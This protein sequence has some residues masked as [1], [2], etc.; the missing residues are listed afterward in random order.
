[1]RISYLETYLEVVRSGSFSEAAK[2][3]GVSQSAISQQVTSLEKALSCTL[4]VRGV[5]GVLS[6]TPAGEIFLEY[7]ETIVN[8]Y[9]DMLSRI[10]NA[11]STVKG[12]LIL[13]ASAIP[14]NYLLPEILL[15]FQEEY[16]DV[17]IRLNVANT[18]DVAKKLTSQE[19]EIGFMGTMVELPG[20]HMDTWVE[21]KIAFAVYP[22]HPFTKR[23]SINPDELVG[24]ALII[25]EE[26]SGTRQTIEKSLEDQGIPLSICKVALVLGST[27]GVVN[28]IKTGLG[29]GFISTHASNV[30]DLCV[31]EIENLNLTRQILIGYNPKRTNTL[32]HRTFLD[33]VLGW[34]IE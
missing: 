33:F 28:A 11:Q 10:D 15:A 19:C 8:D 1:M 3:I 29:V 4:L 14:G 18:R 26:G 9:Q 12:S 25:R 13:A 27:Q 24:Q 21:D 34:D 2:I 5:P 6:L 16:Q 31:V 17:D 20:H 30:A 22:Q 32:L 7:S 23:K